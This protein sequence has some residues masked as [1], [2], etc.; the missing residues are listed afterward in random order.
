MAKEKEKENGEAKDWRED[1]FEKHSITE[2]EDKS[3]LNSRLL[4]DEFVEEG[5]KQ[6]QPK[7][8]GKKRMFGGRA[9]QD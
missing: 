3:F 1:W 9:S 6:R 7:K 2:D 8:E 5:R 4:A